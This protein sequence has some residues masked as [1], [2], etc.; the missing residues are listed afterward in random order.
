[1]GFHRHYAVFPP[2]LR[3]A[4]VPEDSFI[5]LK[6]AFFTSLENIGVN[7]HGQFPATDWQAVR[8]AGHP[9]TSLRSDALEELLRRYL[10]IL[11]DFLTAR[12]QLNNDQAEDFLQNFVL[13]KILNREIIA[14][15]DP[16]RG[17]FRSF[18]VNTASRF[19]ISELRRAQ[20]QKRSPEAAS[21]SLDSIPKGELAGFARECHQQLDL[22][23]ARRVF[24]QAVR[25]MRAECASSD[26]PDL[27]GIFEGR[28]LR[29]LQRQL[30]PLSNTELMRRFGFK[31]SVAVSN[32][33]TTARRMFAR[34]FRAVVT[35]HVHDKT[36]LDTEIRDLKTILALDPHT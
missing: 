22:A 6:D 24:A 13:Q 15:A 35:E 9:A 25:R 4:I 8:A 2:T 30:E 21:V 32:A 12:F 10:P 11:K 20:A 18:L 3:G 14:R 23:F 7:Q 29:P 19:V 27:W 16:A 34:N 31:S 17:R 33:I 5:L 1:M 26:R 36:L 28:F